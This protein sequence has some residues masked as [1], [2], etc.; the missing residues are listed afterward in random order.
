MRNVSADD[1][2]VTEMQLLARI[3]LLTW[4]AEG[5]QAAENENNTLW[6]DSHPERHCPLACTD[7]SALECLWREIR[8]RHLYCGVNVEIPTLVETHLA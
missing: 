8:T 5:Q 4:Q 2:G 6:P 1:A 7:R 3:L